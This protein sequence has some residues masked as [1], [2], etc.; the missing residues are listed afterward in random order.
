VVRIHSG[1]MSDAD[2]FWLVIDPVTGKAKRHP[3]SCT[4]WP[5][6]QRA[7]QPLNI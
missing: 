4:N 1:I 6:G 3:R 5:R 7:F 2:D